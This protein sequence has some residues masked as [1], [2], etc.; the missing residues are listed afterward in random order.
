M[1]PSPVLVLGC[2]LIGTSLALALTEAG[3]EVHLDD[4]LESNVEL[5]VARG[6]GTADPVDAPAVVVVAVPPTE[7]AACVALA[8]ETWPDA[9]V[10]DVA[11]VKATLQNKIA[12]LPGNERYVGSHP[13][14]GSERSGPMAAY[15]RLFEGR[16]WAV[17]SRAGADA[18]SIARVVE[19][20][21]LVGAV[22][23][24]MD[25]EAHDRAVAVVSHVPHVLAVLT[26]ARLHGAPQDHLAL[27]GPGLRDVTRIAGSDIALWQEILGANATEVRAVLEQVRGDLDRVIDS[28]GT[29]TDRLGDVLQSG[30]DGTKLIPG[31]HGEEVAALATVF[32]SVPDEPGELSR[33][34]AHTGESGVNIE[35]IRIDHEL[36]RRVGQ[37]EIA[38]V[39]A[40]AARLVEA[41]TARGWSAYS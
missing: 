13:M 20:A 14:A 7:V 40:Q 23:L 24:E 3:V 4:I 26:A 2:G 30:Q 15:A 11:S 41:L 36:G 16:P 22:P 10:T 38:V 12:A 19:I 8:L 5:A 1:S 39:A 17:T 29:D 25:A 35:D 18:A 37:V 32:V 27:S 31:K 33:L 28:I 34:M 9:T 6:A 21:E